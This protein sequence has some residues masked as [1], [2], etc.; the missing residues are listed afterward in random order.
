MDVDEGPKITI[1]KI[2]KDEVDFVM[3]DVDLAY[4]VRTC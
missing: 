2:A 1:R 4:V 3:S